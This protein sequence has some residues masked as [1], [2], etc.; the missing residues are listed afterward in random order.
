MRNTLLVKEILQKTNL[1]N[2]TQKESNEKK[3]II[4]KKNDLNMN[5]VN[6][7]V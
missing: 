1:I 3:I 2:L 6:N 7:Y 4:D 5:T